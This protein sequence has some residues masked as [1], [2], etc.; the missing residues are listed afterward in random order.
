MV[1]AHGFGCDQ[2]MWRFVAP[3]FEDRF[4]VVLF[5]HVG[6]AAPTWRPTTPS[7]TAPWT[8]TRTTSWRSARRST[9]TTS[10]SSATRSRAM[11]GVLA[12]IAEPDRFAK[13]VLVGP[14]PRYIDDGDYVGGFSEA[15]IDELLDFARQQ[16]PR[17]VERDGAGD[18]GQPR[19][20]RARRRAHGELLPHR[21]RDRPPVRPRH[22]PLRQPRR[23]RA[24]SGRRRWSC[25]AAT[26]PSRRRG[27]RVRPRRACPS[28]TLVVL[29]AT[30][31]CPNLSAP[32]ETAEAIE[33][34]VADDGRS[35]RRSDA[36][37]GHL[38]ALHRRGRRPRAL[39][40]APCGYL[41]TAPDGTILKV[42]QTFLDL[43][44]HGPGS[45]LSGAAGS[46]TCSRRRTH[47]PRDALRADAADAGPGPRDRARPGR[48]RRPASAGPGV[49][50]ALDATA[51]QPVVIRTAVFDA[52]ERRE[53]EPSCSTRSS[54]RRSRSASHRA[55]PHA[56]ADPDPAGAAGHPGAR[57]R[58]RLPARRA[59]AT[60]SAAT[61]TTCSRSRRATGWCS[62]ATYAARASRPPSS[63]PRPAT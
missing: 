26:T 11:I 45:D 32:D 5:D 59:P 1:F 57:R 2:N 47:L 15:D 35:R 56:A 48:R 52:T 14:S 16:L 29:D 21:S 63:R 50:A 38:Q 61:S 49:N 19:P 44:G 18:H 31:H 22:V 24:R 37:D 17:L 8:A 6:A 23:P 27:R 20:A 4:R 36:V 28:S 46:P 55:R 43:D 30:G 51:G 7:A 13:L 33:A 3:G 54:G 34:F 60:R 62:S 10:S 9:C 58:G 39:R 41:S 12:A 40:R 25:S 53:Y 42:N